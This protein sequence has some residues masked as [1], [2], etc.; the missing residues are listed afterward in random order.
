LRNRSVSLFPVLTVAALSFI[1]RTLLQLLFGSRGFE[2]TWM[3][4]KLPLAD[5]IGFSFNFTVFLLI[6]IKWPWV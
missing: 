1:G 5:L 2:N 6:A 3:S 4:S